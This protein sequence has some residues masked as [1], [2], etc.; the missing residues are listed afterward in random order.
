MPVPSFLPTELIAEI[1]VKLMKTETLR[2]RDLRTLAHLCLVSKRF[3]PFARQEL[4]RA[5]SLK[6]VEPSPEEY[7]YCHSYRIPQAKPSRDSLLLAATLKASPEIADLVGTLLLDLADRAGGEG[8]QIVKEVL[9]ACPRITEVEIARFSHDEGEGGDSFAA[10][11]SLGKNIR[12]V[13]TAGVSAHPHGTLMSVLFDF[14]LQELH[15][16]NQHFGDAVTFPF[17]SFQLRSYTHLYQDDRGF[18][19]ILSA[20]HQSL[21]TLHIFSTGEAFDLTP[22]RNLMTLQYECHMH[23][24]AT[25]Q[26]IIS[27]LSTLPPSLAS[28]SLHSVY[29]SRHEP[30]EEELA[31]N[32]ELGARRVLH[33]LP[34]SLRYLN[35]RNFLLS[36]DYILD[37]IASPTAC[38]NLRRLIV[39]TTLA[40]ED[41][42]E[43]PRFEA[44]MQAERRKTY[45]VPWMKAYSDEEVARAERYIA[46]QEQDE[47]GFGLEGEARKACDARGIRMISGAE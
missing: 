40:D 30:A 2:Q 41:A 43:L 27:T 28:L 15:L 6:I 20:S 16:V 14:D 44:E 47:F 7:Y 12:I 36:P 13:H 26:D 39:P 24:G 29:W 33:S 18:Q 10:A 1:F 21:R 42:K 9:T 22:F 19:P 3:L 11:L 23:E 4:Y 5:I 17:P 46:E 31:H 37:F 35:L 38:P 25:S 8:A 45:D 32:A 34:D